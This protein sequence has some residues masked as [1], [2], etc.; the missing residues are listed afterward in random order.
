MGEDDGIIR[1]FKAE[2]LKSFGYALFSKSKLRAAIKNLVPLGYQD[3][4]GFHF[5]T[6]PLHEARC[7]FFW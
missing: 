3:E 4:T 7:P 1:R 5:G 6:Q 2:V